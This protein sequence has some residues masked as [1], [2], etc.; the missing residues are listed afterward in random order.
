MTKVLAR[1]MSIGLDEVI[2]RHQAYGIKGRKIA[3]NLHLIRSVVEEAALHDTPVAII[4]V[5]LKK[6]FDYVDH[7]FLIAAAAQCEIGRE[8]EQ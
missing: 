5:D 6:A 8:I 3:D 7:S 2:G 4:Q 1:R